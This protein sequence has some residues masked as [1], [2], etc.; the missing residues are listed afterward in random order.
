[1]P[2]L[3]AAACQYLYE[4]WGLGYSRSYLRVAVSALRAVEDM[5]WPPAFVNSR[6]W[7]CVKWASTLAVVRPYADLGELSTFALACTGK[8]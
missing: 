5:G 4:L 3:E 1:M 8:A 6:V 7:Q 2:E